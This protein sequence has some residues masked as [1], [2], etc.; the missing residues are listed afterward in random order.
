MTQQLILMDTRAKV[1]IDYQ[2][3]KE[4]DMDIQLDNGAEGGTLY[5]TE[6]APLSTSLIPPLFLLSRVLYLF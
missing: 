6:G 3:D 1:D 5:L 4:V 2:V